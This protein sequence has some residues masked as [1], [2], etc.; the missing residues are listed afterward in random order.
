LNESAEAALVRRC[1]TGDKEAFRA[2]V[3]QHKRIIFGTAYLMTRDRG[4]AE[5]AVQEALLQMWK[6]LPSL[7][8]HG[9]LKAWLLRIV[10]NEVKQQL[11][12]RR[13]ATVPLE[14]AGE[15][16]DDSIGAETAM[17]RDEERKHLH[18]AL[19]MLPPE[20]REAVVLRYFSDLSVPEV[21]VVMG[22]R[23]GTIK[24]RL[25]RAL[26]RLGEILRDDEMQGE[27]R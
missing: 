2:L 23:A 22:Q 15:A 17:V 13:V 18:Q 1:Q 11:R 3:E 26:H 16:A 19:G 4:M 10:A 5:D 6:H 21:A 14:Q 25:S 20:Q 27:G 24:S 12:K 7:R 9:S 8:L